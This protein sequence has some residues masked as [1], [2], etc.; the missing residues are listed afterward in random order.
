MEFLKNQNWVKLV[1]SKLKSLIPVKQSTNYQYFPQIVKQNSPKLS[2]LK[3]IGTRFN[4][5]SIKNSPRKG[6]NKAN[7]NDR[8]AK[9]LEKKVTFKSVD[10]GK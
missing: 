9:P 1:I 3:K 7:D 4:L 10:G 6:Y 2:L 5:N 8:N